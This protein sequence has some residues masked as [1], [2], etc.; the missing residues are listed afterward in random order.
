M[1]DREIVGIGIR[2]PKR[3]ISADDCQM[4]L[5]LGRDTTILG[6]FCLVVAMHMSIHDFNISGT[7]VGPIISYETRVCRKNRIQF[8]NL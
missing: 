2:F 3:F 7:E 4:R 5:Y 8:L 6:N 1:C